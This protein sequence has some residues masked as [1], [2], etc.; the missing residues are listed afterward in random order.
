METNRTAKH[1]VEFFYDLVCVH[2]YL[3]FTRLS[4]ALE[5]FRKTGA[6]V[7]VVFRPFQLVP[8]EPADGRPLFEVHREGF[9][10][11]MARTISQDRSFGAQDGLDVSF[12]RAVFTNTFDAHR[13]VAAAAEQGKGERMA[14]RL[15]RAYFSDG[16][17]I[18][19]AETLRTLPEEVG[20]RP[21][22]VSAEVLRERLDRVHEA[23]VTSVPLFIFDGGAAL[24]GARS[25]DAFL[26]ALGQLV[27][28]VAD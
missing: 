2:S 19:D 1:R 20:V 14:E 27:S 17:N 4:R 9:G 16:L 28:P 7:D 10:E 13:L 18:A 26:E 11:E 25:T 8:K 21:G 23:G 24:S 22:G 15:F 3:G 6:E 5:Q 12:D